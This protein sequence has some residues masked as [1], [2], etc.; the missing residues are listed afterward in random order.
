MDTNS[1]PAYVE[2]ARITKLIKAARQACEEELEISLVAKTLEIA[3]NSFAAV[4]DLPGG[5][6]R[7]IVS[8]K[9]LDP[10]GVDTVLAADQYRFSDYARAPVLLLAYGVS[11]PS[12]RTDVD[13]VRVR[14]TVGYPSTDSPPEEVPE[15]IRQAMH[16]FIAHWFVNREAVDENAKA[17]LPMGVR[18]L[19]GKFRKNMGV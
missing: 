19:L 15:P 2:A 18:Y 8:V 5:P 11:W 9:Y 16:L 17:E 7:S 6:V 12:A 4:I 10:D 14:Y 3:G 1:P 13:S